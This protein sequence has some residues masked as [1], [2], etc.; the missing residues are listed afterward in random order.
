MSPLDKIIRQIIAAQGALSLA[1]YM[2][3]ALQNPDHGYYRVREPLGREGDFVTAPEISQMFGEMIGVWCAEA[4]RELGAP[5]SFVLIE[6]GAGRGT[7]MRD[8]LRATAK[9][10]GF[11]AAKKLYLIE[12]NQV[13][14]D[15]QRET[16]ADYAPQFIDDIVQAPPMPVLILANEF[17]DALPVRQFEKT[18][19]GWG[20]RMVTVE[21]DALALSLRPMTDAE[22]ALIPAVLREASPGAVFEFSPQAQHIMR[23]LSRAVAANQGAMLIIDYGFVAPSGAPTVQAVSRHA[24]ANI[25]ERPGKVDLTAHVDFTS[26]GQ[27][28]HH[29]G[30]NVSPVIGQGEFL[31]NLGIAIRAESLKKQA[32]PDQAAAID[33]ALLRLTDDAQMGGVFKVMEVRA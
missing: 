10:A 9:V 32:T 14:R 16:L 28:A 33:E 29:A 15:R 27:A 18:F 17:F 19:R 24:Y 2:E 26:L 8:A 4:W 25:L 23:D 1:A 31:R 20:E 3:L 21:G 12:S 13:L 11:H 6:L 22:T 5:D 7:M 30:L